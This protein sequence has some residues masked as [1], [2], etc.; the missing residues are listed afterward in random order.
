[1]PKLILMVAL[2]VAPVAVAAAD[3]RPLKELPEVADLLTEM[4]GMLGASPDRMAR[5]CRGFGYV[6]T[7]QGPKVYC[8]KKDGMTRADPIAQV[9]VGKAS[10]GKGISWIEWN[11]PNKRLGWKVD[12]P[13][14][15]RAPFAAWLFHILVE[16]YGRATKTRSVVE[17]HWSTKRRQVIYSPGLTVEIVASHEGSK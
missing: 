1:M 14:F 4:D 7:V 2:V 6:A 16:R 12:G 8:E 10:F 13:N 5:W 3:F 15:D 17:Y 9:F 11:L